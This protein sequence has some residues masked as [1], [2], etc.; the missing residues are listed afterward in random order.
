MCQQLL[1]DLVTPAN[2]LDSAFCLIIQV[3]DKTH[4]R[5][6]PLSTLK[7]FA[8]YQLTARHGSIDYCTL[9]P[10]VQT[11][12]NSS[13]SLIIPPIVNFQMRALGLETL[14]KKHPLPP[15]HSQ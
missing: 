9:S 8:F 15:H 6:A 5:S 1:T 10:A 14:L 12:F 2:L 7:Y 3:T 4:R 11:I 13:D